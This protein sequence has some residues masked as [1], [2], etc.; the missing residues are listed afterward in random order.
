[1]AFYHPLFLHSANSAFITKIERIKKSGKILLDFIV[2]IRDKIVLVFRIFFLDNTF[3]RKSQ[4]GISKIGFNFNQRFVSNRITFFRNHSF[5]VNLLESY[6]FHSNPTGRNLK[7]KTKWNS[8]NKNTGKSPIFQGNDF[9]GE[10][11]ITHFSHAEYLKDD[12]LR[13]RQ[14]KKPTQGKEIK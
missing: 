6:H 11:G 1:M 13:R 4:K 14:I 9:I 2:K 5:I 7:W 10:K 12:D 3:T 8:T